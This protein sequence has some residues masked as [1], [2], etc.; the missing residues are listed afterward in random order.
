MLSRILAY[1]MTRRAIYQGL[2]GES[3]TER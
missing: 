2:S 3:E 1:G